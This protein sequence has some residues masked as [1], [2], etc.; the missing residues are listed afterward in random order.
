MKRNF[1]S[2]ILLLV[3]AMPVLF[4]AFIAG[5][6]FIPCGF[7]NN[8]AQ[9]SLPDII[10]TPIPTII[11]ATMPVTGAGGTSESVQTK[12]VTN[13]ETLLSSWVNAGYPETDPFNLVDLNGSAC[14]AVFT[15]VQVLF[16]EAN[17]W[18]TGAPAC[19]TCHNS[20][21]QAA[22]VNMDLSSYA[23]I[24]AGSRRTSA[25]TQRTDILGGGNWSASKLNDMLFV[26]KKMPYG[27]PP[28]TVPE[29]GPVVLIG[30]LVATGA[31]I[32]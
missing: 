22:A 1:Q 16:Q 11:P 18:Y 9:A 8:C 32:P 20:N 25:D 23:G 7:D 5:L 27:R 24:L 10:H 26:Q 3:F 28:G 6:Y 30:T 29:Q 21:L 12:C 31:G 17:L 13:A 19:I 2:W 4:I 15:D 14:Q